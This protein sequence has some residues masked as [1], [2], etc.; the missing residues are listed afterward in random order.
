[1]REPNL[2]TPQDYEFYRPEHRPNE[3]WP[4]RDTPDALLRA[5]N[6][7]HD[8]LRKQE[9][10]NRAH[11]ATINRLE[12]KTDWLKYKNWLTT[13]ALVVLWEIFKALVLHR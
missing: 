10:I 8:D 1:M 7:A 3:G 5:L 4:R 2:L 9:K 12:R 13:A 6:H 11:L